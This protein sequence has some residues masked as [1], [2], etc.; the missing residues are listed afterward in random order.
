MV[1]K[2]IVEVS[3]PYRIEAAEEGGYLVQFVDL[4]EAF[5]EA[6]TLEEAHFNA[7]EVLSLTLQ[8]R[9]DDDFNVPKP[10]VVSGDDVYYSVPEADIQVAI[11]VHWLREE[12]GVSL[13]DLARN[14]KTSWPSAQRLEKSGN[15]PTLNK[16]SEVAASFGKRLIV[17]FA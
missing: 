13:A 10:S 17:S 16:L 15:N 11:Q 2:N 4:D 9:V 6:E 5:S 3:Y 12:L 8:G 1:S 7:A 14:L